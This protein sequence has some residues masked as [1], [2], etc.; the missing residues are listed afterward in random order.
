MCDSCS[1]CAALEA[2]LARA[3]A[4]I[5]ALRRTVTRLRAI[6]ARARAAC[7]SLAAQADKVLARRS[8]VPRGTWAFARGLREAAARVAAFLEV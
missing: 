4:E 7:V 8:G 3:R 6:I 2:E 5:E 1:N